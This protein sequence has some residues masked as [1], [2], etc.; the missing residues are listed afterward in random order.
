MGHRSSEARG[1]VAEYCESC[2]F[3]IVLSKHSSR[4]NRASKVVDCGLNMVGAR[5]RMTDDDDLRGCR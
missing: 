1:A 2:E 4:Y 5:T 3:L